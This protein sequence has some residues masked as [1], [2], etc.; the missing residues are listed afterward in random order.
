MNNESPN[1]LVVGGTVA[2]MTAVIAAV[3]KGARATIVS[4][5]PL[6]RSSDVV[7]GE[8]IAAVLNDSYG[9]SVDQHVRDTLNA[10][11]DGADEGF[12]RRVC[13]RA[14][15]L[16]RFLARAGVLFNRTTEGHLERIKTAGHTRSRT[17][18]VDDATGQHVVRVLEEQIRR[19]EANDLI[20]RQEYC[21][22][23]SPV[24][25]EDNRCRGVVVM[26]RNNHTC[27]A[28]KADAVVL[29]DDECAGLGSEP[30]RAGIFAAGSCLE[31]C[32]RA[33][34][35]S[36]NFLAAKLVSGADAGE[37]ACSYVAG[38]ATRA[39][40]LGESLFERAGDREEKS[41]KTLL[42]RTEGENPYVLADELKAIMDRWTSG[43]RDVGALENLAARTENIQ[44]PDSS[45]WWNDSLVFARDL[46]NKIAL[47]LKSL[48]SFSTSY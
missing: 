37:A 6:I 21:V 5:M 19:Y 30:R 26:K 27:V 18:R 46:Q 34:S 23:L 47:V 42:D 10:T 12:V 45:Q 48:K 33:R 20:D 40:E 13:E 7:A 22:P 25:D 31:G 35:L 17:V 2:G 11:G 14:P 32:Q 8:G 36:G 43:D 4:R 1:I 39:D 9:D 24:F 41:N 28:L 16:V 29:A 44:L 38:L 3:E 15:V